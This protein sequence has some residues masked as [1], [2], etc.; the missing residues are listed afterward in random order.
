MMNNGMA[1]DDDRSTTVDA[2]GHAWPLMKNGM[3]VDKGMARPW[4]KEG[5]VVDE[6]GHGHG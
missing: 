6:D 5:T 1:M 2:D 3:T 4:M